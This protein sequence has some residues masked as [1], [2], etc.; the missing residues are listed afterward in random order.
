MLRAR[1]LKSILGTYIQGHALLLRY[2]QQFARSYPGTAAIFGNPVELVD[3]V[4]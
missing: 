4:L 1:V 3:R 2:L